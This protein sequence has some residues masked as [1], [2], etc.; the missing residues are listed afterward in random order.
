MA[1]RDH[2]LRISPSIF[3]LHKF[4]IQGGDPIAAGPLKI[5]RVVFAAS[6]VGIISF[7]EDSAVRRQADPAEFM[8]AL[9]AAHVV[10]AAVRKSQFSVLCRLL[11]SRVY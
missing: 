2:R 1:S 10:A 6:L 4:H 8:A 11:R 9:C 3:I 7:P 5:V